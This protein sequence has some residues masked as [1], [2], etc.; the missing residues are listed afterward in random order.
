MVFKGILFQF[1][2]HLFSKFAYVYILVTEEH[3]A[4]PRPSRVL[5]HYRHAVNMIGCFKRQK[6]VIR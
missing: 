5:Y 6:Y 1:F 2:S 4:V 3:V